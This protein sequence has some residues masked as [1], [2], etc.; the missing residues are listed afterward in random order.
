M[1]PRPAPV[2]RE[3]KLTPA[4]GRQLGT[5]TLHPDRASK[6]ELER[7]GT[8][9]LETGPKDESRPVK[10]ENQLRKQARQEGVGRLDSLDNLALDM[11]VRSR[12]PGRRN[13]RLASGPPTVV[14]AEPL[15]GS[16]PPAPMGFRLV[17]RE[18]V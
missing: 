15:P 2:V 4:Q 16:P 8:Q 17:K 10:T 12:R 1:P 14:D 7:M 6:R 5:W 13:L 11:P 9:L 18:A 3:P